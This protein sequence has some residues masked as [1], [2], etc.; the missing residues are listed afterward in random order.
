[1]I[2]LS[3]FGTEKP[4]DALIELMLAKARSYHCATKAEFV[5]GYQYK[6]EGEEPASWDTE[7]WHIRSDVQAP[8]MSMVMQ[9]QVEG[10]Q[11]MMEGIRAGYELG[12]KPMIDAAKAR[13][14][15]QEQKKREKYWAQQRGQEWVQYIKDQGYEFEAVPGDLQQPF[16]KKS[17]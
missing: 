1:V 3:S 5:F 15:K 14:H 8:G 12:R 4:D 9:L 17:K 16:G 7:C 13:A 10:V 2:I 6:K 11:G